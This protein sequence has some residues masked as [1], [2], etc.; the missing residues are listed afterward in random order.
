MAKKTLIVQDDRYA[1]YD[2]VAKIWRIYP[3]R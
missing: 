1:I 2:A 3:I